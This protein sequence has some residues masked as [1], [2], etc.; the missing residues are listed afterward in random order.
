M[1]NSRYS[2]WFDG[3]LITPGHAGVWEVNDKVLGLM[4]RYWDGTQWYFL[5][6]TRKEAVLQFQAGH[7][8]TNQTPTFRGLNYDPA[9]R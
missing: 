2:E 8:S 3:A 5:S 6:W 1:S 9:L 4:W 7:V